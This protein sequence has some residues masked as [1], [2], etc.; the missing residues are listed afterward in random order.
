MIGRPVEEVLAGGERR[1]WISSTPRPWCRWPGA[2]SNPWRGY[3]PTGR[4]FENIDEAYFFT[5]QGNLIRKAWGLED[6]LERL[7]QLGL[8]P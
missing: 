7:C 2:G 4:R 1:Y 5:F 6:N 3:P 8:R